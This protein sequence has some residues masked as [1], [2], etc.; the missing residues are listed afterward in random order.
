MVVTDTELVLDGDA[1]VAVEGVAVPIDMLPA[2]QRYSEGHV[3]HDE[4][5][6]DALNVP[7][8]QGWQETAPGP[9]VLY[10][11]AGHNICA[12]CCCMTRTGEMV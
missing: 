1:D 2:G 12:V 5:P 4:A 6:A 11:P 10:V 8:G 9:P 7:I 3:E